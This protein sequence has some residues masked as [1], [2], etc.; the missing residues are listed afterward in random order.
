MIRKGRKVGGRKG[1]EE[2]TGT[3]NY[4]SEMDIE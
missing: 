1:E 2:E 3:G 4:I